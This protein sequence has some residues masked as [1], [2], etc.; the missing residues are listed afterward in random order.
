M[1]PPALRQVWEGRIR[2]RLTRD[3]WWF[4]LVLVGVGLASF[5]TG[6][7]LLYMALAAMLALLVVQNVLGEANL[8]GIRVERRLPADLFAWEGASGAFW[9]E[10]RRPALP[11][12]AL[13]VEELGEGEASALLGVIP[14]GSSGQAEATWTFAARGWR[15]LTAVRVSSTWPFGLFVRSRVLPLEGE[16][17]VYP[18]RRPGAWA[19]AGQ[20]SG[21]EVED[22]RRRGGDG[23][24]VGL[25]PY[26]PGDPVRRVHWRTSARVGQPVVVERAAPLALHHVVRVRTDAPDL[27][28]EL[29][30]ACGQVVRRLAQGGAVGF[31]LGEQ[32]IP[33]GQGPGHRR[34]LLSA[35]A[36]VQRGGP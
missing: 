28:E 3:G 12:V 33:P 5:N 19:W 26:A 18:P 36:L 1:N 13:R 2:V 23:E 14:A 21:L 22:P 29:G 16:V 11:S 6:N 9:V 8:R 25:R 4:M 34:R 7:N 15:P 32:R 31:E 30:R 27:E 17:L 10:A 20:G 35:L 24:L